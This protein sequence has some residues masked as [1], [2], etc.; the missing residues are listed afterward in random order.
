MLCVL[1]L[2]PMILTVFLDD[3]ILGNATLKASDRTSDFMFLD[4]HKL[5]EAAQNFLE[6]PL[7]IFSLATSCREMGDSWTVIHTGLSGRNYLWFVWAAFSSLYCKRE[8]MCFFCFP[9]LL[10]VETL[11]NFCTDI[12][13]NMSHYPLS[14]KR[15]AL[16]L[17][18]TV[19]DRRL[20]LCCSVVNHQLW[21]A[22]G[23]PSKIWWVWRGFALYGL[24]ARS[25]SWTQ[26]TTINFWKYFLKRIW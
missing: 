13:C 19:K 8:W 7:A 1:A 6:L 17:A 12:A 9:K 22:Q 2:P 14:A 24:C 23:V 5:T 21:Q 4:P 11:Y 16:R 18:R 10:Y 26:L 3:A 20:Q 15:Q 25:V